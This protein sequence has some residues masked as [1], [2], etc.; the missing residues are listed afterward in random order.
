MRNYIATDRRG[1]SKTLKA[2]SAQ[3]AAE[4]LFGK[5]YVRTN[6]VDPELLDTPDSAVVMS[7]GFDFA[8]CTITPAP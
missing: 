4:R 1:E 8:I 2:E 6:G 5:R 3:R 7:E